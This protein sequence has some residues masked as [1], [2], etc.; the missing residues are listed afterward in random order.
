M[1][2]EMS[3]KKKFKR[4]EEFVKRMK[5]VYE[6]A[7]AALRKSQEEMRKYAD[8]KEVSQRSIE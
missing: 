1:G 6:E 4:A 2:F 7:E 3:K 8:R 5:E